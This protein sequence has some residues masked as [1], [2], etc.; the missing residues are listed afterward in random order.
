M[1]P[2][3]RRFRLRSAGNGI[4]TVLSTSSH[5][6]VRHSS[7]SLGDLPI[8]GWLLALLLAFTAATVF[9]RENWPLP[10]FQIGVFALLAAYTVLRPPVAMDR[11][12][13]GMQTV[14]FCCIVCLPIW[15]ILQL[16]RGATSSAAD[17]FSASL[18]WAALAAVFFLAYA[19]ARG[20]ETRPNTSARRAFLEVFLGFATAEAVLCLTQ[21]FTSNGRVLWLYSSGYD[22]VFGTFQYR[23]NYAQFVE[24]AL[25]IALWRALRDRSHGWA[26]ALIGGTLYASVIASASR[27]GFALCTAELLAVLV[28]GLIRL[29][30]PDTG[31]PS[32]SA[33]AMLA[34]IPA[35]AIVFTMVVG[36]EN[37]RERFKEQDPYLA[38]REF[39]VA[40]VD[41]A[42]ERPLTGFGLD[43][44]PAVYQ[45]YAVKDFFFY[46]NHTHNDWAEF[47]ADG[48]LP[49][50][51]LVLVPFLMAVPSAVRNPWG[52][53]LIAV[54]LHACMDYPFPRPAVSG[55]M[56]ALLGLLYAT[57]A[58]PK[59]LDSAAP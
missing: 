39:F 41:M 10:V 9:V 18:R 50:L 33:T 24:L 27:A 21:L 55:W 2:W 3:S 11:T 40:A 30:D 16:V 34:V 47:A 8:L 56:F 54:M 22:E 35:I 25:P 29:R 37:L 38:R 12:G 5:A 4:L 49:F 19:L 46:A 14:V 23:N 58:T 31:A 6:R 57:R 53:G 1:G 28:I 43:T 44:F 42:R 15:G 45:R 36:W 59:R 26:Y 48:G 7:A 52:I 51:L 20:S 17:T 13:F 32:R